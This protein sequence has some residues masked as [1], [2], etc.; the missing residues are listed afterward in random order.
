MEQSR[1]AITRRALTLIALLTACSS[2][3][4][5]GDAASVP[6]VTSS[7]AAAELDL[8]GLLDGVAVAAERVDELAPATELEAS[9][10]SVAAFSTAGPAIAPPEVATEVEIV[11]IMYG[12]LVAGLEEAAWDWA[13]FTQSDYAVRV[14]DLRSDPATGSA[15]AEIAAWSGTNC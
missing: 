11:A 3:G 1:G 7:V 10:R 4:V 14:A 2:G 6:S 13:T 8:C 12:T 15:L 9:L 5:P